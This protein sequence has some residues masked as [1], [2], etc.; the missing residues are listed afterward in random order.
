MICALFDWHLSLSI[1]FSKVIHIVVHASVISHFSHVWLFVT[2]WTVAHQTPL[3]MGLSRQKYWSGL[4]CCP[5]GDLPNPGIQLRSP[6][7]Q[8]D[9]LPAELPRKPPTLY[10]LLNFSTTNSPIRAVYKYLTIDI[11]RK[12]CHIQIC[13]YEKNVH[14][15]EFNAFKS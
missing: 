2:P 7:L 11:D 5:P 13:H 12:K 8:A 6:A 4:P 3:S 9:S 14:W 15:M 10:P 1:V